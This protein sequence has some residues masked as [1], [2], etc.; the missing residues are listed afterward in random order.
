MGMSYEDAARAGIAHLHPAHPGGGPPRAGGP[1]PE[2]AA[3]PAPAGPQRRATN[4]L[5]QNRTEARFDAA[6]AALRAGGEIREYWFEP[7]KLRLAGR[8]FYTPD[9]LAVR[10]DGSLAAVEIKGFLRDDAAVKV[11]VAAD[12]YKFIDFFL[13]FAD[14]RGWD[15]R[16]VTPRGIGPAAPRWWEG[17]RREP[18]PGVDE[19]E[20]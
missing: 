4:A 12:K 15:V 16:R 18:P 14:G 19:G 20:S 2:P 6:L 5:G 1:P 13:A 7:A 8:T 10:A 11:K 17:P 9:F 3:A